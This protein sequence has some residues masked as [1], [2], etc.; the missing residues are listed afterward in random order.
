MWVTLDIV[1]IIH[2]GNTG[3]LKTTNYNF[4]HF[5]EYYYL[6]MSI[7]YYIYSKCM[8]ENRRKTLIALLCIPRGRGGVSTRYFQQI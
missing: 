7:L 6:I 1:Y 3:Y 5:C 8:G 2:Y 4:I